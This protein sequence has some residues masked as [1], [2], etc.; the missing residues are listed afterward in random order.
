MAPAPGFKNT[1]KS[2]YFFFGPKKLAAIAQEDALYESPLKR[3]KNE[4]TTTTTTTKPTNGSDRSGS[5]T[6][7]KDEEEKK[8]IFVFTGKKGKN[9]QNSPP[10]STENAS[11]TAISLSAGIVPEGKT[12]PAITST[13][14]RNYQNPAEKTSSNLSTT[15][16]QRPNGNKERNQNVVSDQIINNHTHSN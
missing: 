2:Y 4:Q 1:P 3:R 8:G 15:K 5:A 7:N 14:S 11:A 9:S 13:L 10:S 6:V 16:K 12:A